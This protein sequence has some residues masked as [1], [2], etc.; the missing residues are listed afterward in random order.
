LSS[1]DQYGSIDISDYVKE[2]DDDVADYKLRDEN[3]GDQE[4]KQTIPYSVETSFYEVLESQLGMLKLD[5]K[6][7]KIAEQIIG[8]ID[9]DGYLRR[10]TRLLLMTLRSGRM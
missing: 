7:A 5:D 9:E 6:E 8:S 4:E 1:E 3:Y 10:E 2:G